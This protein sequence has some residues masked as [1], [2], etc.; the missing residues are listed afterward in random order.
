MKVWI[1]EQP[2]LFDQ[3]A[4]SRFQEYHAQNPAVYEWFKKFTFE[5]INA[6]RTRLGAKMVAE[7]LR[8][9]STVSG[10]D[11]WKI[12]NS[13]VA[14]YARLFARDFPEHQNLFSTRKS[15]LDDIG[16]NV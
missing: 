10:N 9:Q 6:G 13:H 15:K 2:S 7:R 4:D 8:W 14:G 12:N 11:G 16:L 5:A 1:N 3:K